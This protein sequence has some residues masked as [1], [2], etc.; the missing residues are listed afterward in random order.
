MS[1][2]RKEDVRELIDHTGDICVSIYMPTQP[3]HLEQQRAEPIRLR[4][5]IDEARVQIARFTPFLRHPDVERLLQPAHQILAQNEEFW[6]EPAT[7][8]AL[9]LGT[10][11]SRIYR[12]PREVE[13]LV[14][15]NG[16]FYIRPLLPLLVEY[17]RFYLLT[18]SQKQ[19]RLFRAS[20][21]S[22]EELDLPDMPTSLD[23]VLA[24]DDPEK[25]LQF[26]GAAG[27]PGAA[28]GR[29]AIFYSVDIPTN[30]KK[31]SLRRFSQQVDVGLQKYLRHETMPLVL[32]C[33]DYLFAIYQ[34]ANSYPHLFPINVA[35]SPDRR[36]ESALHE[37][38]WN[39]V[40]PSFRQ[41]QQEALVRFGNL[42][43]QGRAL[44][45]VKRIV[46]AAFQGQVDTLFTA[47]NAQQRGFFNQST[48]EVFLDEYDVPKSEELLNLAAVYTLSNGG[49]VYT[50]QPEDLPEGIKLAALL[51]F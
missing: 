50:C 21:S 49:M 2:L 27:A 37:A 41:A 36:S 7:G 29:S 44:T 12:L 14:M 43:G 39:L 6:R 32:A 46:A 8:L 5:L 26:H 38:A 13:P 24:Y 16:R 48:C 40:Q 20:K 9:F 3:A 11:F 42:L 22:M 10:D 34:Q 35:G 19:V 45:D 33:V 47:V 28:G 17:G 15:V 1:P 31:E 18:F 25:Q 30:Y 4:N 23:Q 51:R